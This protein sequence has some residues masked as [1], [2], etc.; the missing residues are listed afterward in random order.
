VLQA[1]G[2]E[3]GSMPDLWYYSH[4]VSKPSWRPV[5]FV[6]AYMDGDDQALNWL[7]LTDPE[8]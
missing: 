7:Q 8:G 4:V 5:Q 1:K 6:P 3:Y 2:V